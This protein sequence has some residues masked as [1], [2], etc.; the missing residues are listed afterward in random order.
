MGSARRAEEAEEDGED[1]GER[2]A[3]EMMLGGEEVVTPRARGLSLGSMASR[4]DDPV[5][6]HIQD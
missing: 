6:S 4:G 3:R 1:E 5:S 2:I